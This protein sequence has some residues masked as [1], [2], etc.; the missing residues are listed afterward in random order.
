MRTEA[1]LR[2]GRE[3]P[4]D[5]P[6]EITVKRGRKLDSRAQAIADYVVNVLSPQMQAKGEETLEESL[7]FGDEAEEEQFSP[8]E[9]AFMTSVLLRKEKQDIK[10]READLARTQKESENARK[11]KKVEP[12]VDKGRTGGSQE[13]AGR[14][15][16]DAGATGG[17]Q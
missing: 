7:D 3:V 12:G 6:L 14:Q 9:K 5:E 16:D 8:S 15:N 2:D 10:A 17:A 11:G 13:R 1:L 4:E